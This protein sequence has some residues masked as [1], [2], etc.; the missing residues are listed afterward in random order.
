MAAARAGGQRPARAAGGRRAGAVV[1]ALA[2]LAV[3]AAGACGPVRYARG[4]RATDAALAE[5]RGAGAE[6]R[7][8]Y[9]WARAT[10]YARAARAAAARSDFEG[11]DRFGREARAAAREALAVARRAAGAGEGAAPPTLRPVPAPGDNGAAAGAAEAGG[12]PPPAAGRR[13]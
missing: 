12:A 8:P 2:A 5:A 10:L 9:W 13:P 6:Q 7:A 1:A 11:A 3:L 4:G